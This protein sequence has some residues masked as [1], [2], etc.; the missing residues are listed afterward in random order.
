MENKPTDP[1]SDTAAKNTL[2]GGN[3]SEN[4]DL[5]KAIAE[6][7]NKNTDLLEKSSQQAK[8]TEDTLERIKDTQRQMNDTRN[9]VY[10][11]FFVLIIMVVGLVLAY[12]QLSITTYGTLIE[13]VSSV[14]THL[15]K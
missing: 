2:T 11:G 12:I 9:L 14:V 1:L 7:L 15:H 4:V 13:K 3:S 8:Q 10:I 6:L 5:P